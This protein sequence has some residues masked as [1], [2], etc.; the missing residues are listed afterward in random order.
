M[1]LGYLA[2]QIRGSNR[3][4]SAQ[5]RQSMSEFAMGI[6]RFRAEH[7]D[8]YAKIA[9]AA[10]LSPGDREFLY[11]SHMQMLTFGEAYFHQFQLGLM[12]PSHWQGFS[13]WIEAYME[14]KEFELFWQQEGSSFSQDYSAWINE[15]LTKQ[16]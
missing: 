6:S 7:A 10:E 12:P 5:S 14:G 2:I 15:R 11:W 3:V 4:A 16:K 1:T 9:A 8:R 13:N